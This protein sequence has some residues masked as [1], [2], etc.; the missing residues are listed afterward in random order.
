MQWVWK[1]SF[2]KPIAQP[3]DKLKMGDMKMRR[4][5][6]KL[7]PK[8]ERIVQEAIVSMRLAR[9]KIS[10]TLL[11]EAKRSISKA[12]ERI[13][14]NGQKAAQKEERDTNGKVPID[15]KKNLNIILKY[16]ELCPENQ[17][18][19]NVLKDHIGQS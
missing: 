18:L 12:F 3:T 17:A 14:E 6:Y 8:C 9:R 13:V 19:R 2:Y 1:V 16:I 11:E 4:R 7:T 10:P 15:K 5:I